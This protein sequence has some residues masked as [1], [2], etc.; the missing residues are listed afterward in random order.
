MVAED[1]A[2]FNV[3]EECFVFLKNPT[4]THVNPEG[5]ADED[6]YIVWGKSNGKY[7]IKDGVLVNGTDKMFALS[8]VEQKVAAI[9]G[10]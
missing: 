7:H 2:E 3:E 4:L 5:F 10:E 6:Y 9:R 8:E 1:E